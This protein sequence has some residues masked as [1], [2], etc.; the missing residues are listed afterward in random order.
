MPSIATPTSAA[1]TSTTPI[2]GADAANIVWLCMPGA[3]DNPC[4]SDLSVT[5]IDPTGRRT[6]SQL[7]PA[8]DPPIDCFYVYPTTS[9]QTTINA[10]LSIDPEE[11]AVASAQAGPFSQVCRVYAPVYQQLTI[12]AL[13]SGR[14]TGANVQKAY[15]GV[16]AAFDDY[17]ASYNHGRGV[18]VIGH[19]QGAMLLADLL[20]FEIDPNPNVRKLLVSA[21]LMGGNVTVTPGKTTGGDFANIPSCGSVSQVGCVVAYSSFAET[22][23]PGAEF[24]RVTGAA[25]MLP[26]PRSGTQQ[27]LCVNPAAPGGVGTLLPYF[28]TTDV[29]RLADGP[30]PAPTTAF[31]SYPDALTARCQTSGDATWLQVTRVASA[32]ATPTLT[33]SEGPAWG[34]HDL[35]VSLALGN[36]VDLVRSEAA[37]VRP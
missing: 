37:A 6:A 23:P 5:T 20:H 32:P 19:S 34:L 3:A 17:L 26:I 24:G 27:I 31:V 33:G 7:V 2:P 11:R 9:R 30:R 8:D 29:V 21:L 22:P 25:G 13:G 1:S 16:K 28:P 18:V 35:D 4:T 14:I 10:D 36:L 12:A 15:D